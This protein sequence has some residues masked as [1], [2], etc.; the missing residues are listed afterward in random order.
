MISYDDLVVQMRRKFPGRVTTE[1]AAWE[2]FDHTLQEFLTRRSKWT[3][4][5]EW[6]SD[7][8]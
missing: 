1:A 6:L 3:G 4:T 7:S 8:L 2:S 5:L